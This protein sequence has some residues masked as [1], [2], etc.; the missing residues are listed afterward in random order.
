[1]SLPDL[2]P[3]SLPAMPAARA[4]ARSRL[5]IVRHGATAPNLAGLRCGGDIDPPLTDTGRRQ[6]IDV[7]RRLAARADRIDLIICS[8]LLRTRESAAILRNALG[9]VELRLV[10][11]F[12]ERR[13]GQW[14]LRSVAETEPMLAAGQTPPGGESRAAFARRVEA[15]LRQIAPALDRR[16]LL[17]ASKGVGRV[18]RELAGE[19]L[20]TPMANAELLELSFELP[21]PTPTSVSAA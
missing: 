2:L 18:L 11:E 4:A 6:F 10:P 12:R 7:A 3:A 9:N 8:D 17:V 14:N 5:L 1:M 21:S 19:P 16:V 15:G 20:S 13:L